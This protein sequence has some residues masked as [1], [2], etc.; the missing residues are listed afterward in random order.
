[1]AGTLTHFKFGNDLYNRL[2]D[3]NIVKDFFIMG[4]QGHDLLFF[5]KLWEYPKRKMYFTLAN[6]LKN[7]KLEDFIKKVRKVKNPELKSFLLGYLAHEILDNKVHPYINMVTSN[8]KDQHSLLESVIDVKINKM[9]TIKKIIPKHLKLTKE[10][11]KEFQILFNNY[12]QDSFISKRILKSINHVYP[13]LF[14]YRFDNLGIKSRIYRLINKKG[15]SFLAYN[16]PNEEMDVEMDEFIK[17]YNEAL[18]ETTKF[19]K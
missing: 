2:N 11:K 18:Y 5:I 19:L 9:K 13:F 1:M 12:F 8:D 17:L 14:L 15:L 6:K 4:N 16:Y 3:K 10:F 7:V